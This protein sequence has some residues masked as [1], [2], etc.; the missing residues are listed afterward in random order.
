MN[1]KNLTV[2]KDGQIAVVT[3][4]RPEALN[5]IN[6][7]TMTEIGHAMLELG[8]DADVRV[9]I[10]TGA[11]KAFAAGADIAEL[12]NKDGM[13]ARHVSQLGQRTFSIVENLPK[14]VI[15]AVNGWALGG[16]LELAMACDVRVASTKAKMGQ[17]EV[18][19][20]A[21]P[22]F[23][24]TQRL[25]RIVG[26]GRAK[27]MIL[28]GTPI[29]AETAL[30]WGLVNKVVEPDALM[31]AAREMAV[32]IAKNGPAAVGLAKACINKGTST[33]VDA[34][35][36]HESDAFGLCFASGEASEGIA[37]FFEKRPASWVKE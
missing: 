24:G 16:G 6:V 34:G 36:T 29:D 28:T 21:V 9:V 18:T 33:D 4:N 17:P 22:G 25:P 31:G 15:A 32:R 2:E 10:V 14:P 37:A 19:I 12:K 26:F 30:S 35:G 5:A 8:G 7:E 13:E 1:L 27:E 20:G 3:I 11:G 23:A